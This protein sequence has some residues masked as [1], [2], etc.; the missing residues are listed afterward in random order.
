MIM[1]EG[2]LTPVPWVHGCIL[3]HQQVMPSGTTLARLTIPTSILR[4]RPLGMGL[5]AWIPMLAPPPMTLIME[6]GTRG[7]RQLVRIHG[8]M[9]PMSLR[10]GAIRSRWICPMGQRMRM[11]C[12]RGARL[13]PPAIGINADRPSL[14]AI[15]PWMWG[16]L[17]VGSIM[18]INVGII[19]LRQISSFVVATGTRVGGVISLCNDIILLHQ[20]VM[21]A[22]VNHCTQQHGPSVNRILEKGIPVF[23]KLAS[24]ALDSTVEFYDKLQKTSAIFL[25][26]LMPFDSIDLHMGFEGLC[27]PGLGLPW[28]AKI[29]TDLMEVLPCLLPDVDSQVTS[30]VTVVWAELNNGYDLL[31]RVLELIVLGVDP[32]LQLSAPVWMGDDIFDF[33]LSFVLYFRLQLKRGLDHDDRTKSLT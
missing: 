28:Y 19:P 4:H 8:S 7:M 29:A 12:L 22:W 1:I 31:W 9:M 32:S 27:P 18:D 23:P 20:L 30:L 2:R 10:L 15:A 13:F 21:D 17:D 5:L 25:L 26:P 24:L 33:C 14:L 16:L 6:H 3:D 11:T